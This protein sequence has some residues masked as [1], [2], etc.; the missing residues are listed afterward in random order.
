M[1]NLPLLSIGAVGFVSVVGHVV[2]PELRALLQAHLAGDTAKAIEIHQRLLP[3]FTGMF[4]T[5]GVMTTKAALELLGL[6][7]GPLRLPLVELSGSETEQLKQD[8]AA[9]GVHL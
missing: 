8:L 9:G 5:Q 1:L 3:I 7:A 4:R 2:S 6:P